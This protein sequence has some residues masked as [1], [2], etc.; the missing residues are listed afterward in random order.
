MRVLFEDGV[1]EGEIKS[2]DFNYSD[3]TI[4]IK[5]DLVN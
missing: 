2:I 3:R 5:G 4:L 1:T